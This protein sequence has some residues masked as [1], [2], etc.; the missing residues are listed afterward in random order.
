MIA[1]VTV[2]VTQGQRRRSKNAKKTAERKKY[3]L[4]L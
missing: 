1:Y 3:L 4:E 2:K